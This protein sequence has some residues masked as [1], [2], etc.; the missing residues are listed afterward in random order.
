MAKKGDFREKWPKRPFLAKNAHFGHFGLFWGPLGT[1][2]TPSGRGFYINPSLAGSRDPLQGPLRGFGEAPGDPGT[3]DPGLGPRMGLRGPRE[4]P[5]GPRGQGFY[6]N[7]SR[8]G[9]AVPRGPPPGVWEPDFPEI[10]GFPRKGLFS[11]KMAILGPSRGPPPE[12]PKRV[13]RGGGGNPRRPGA[14]VP[15][16]RRGQ[17][18]SPWAGA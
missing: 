1:P 10:R 9:P 16:R 2:G 3:G 15:L 17:G 6:I 18:A 13:P 8:R 4:V 11:P 7:P 12:T 14:G 5:E